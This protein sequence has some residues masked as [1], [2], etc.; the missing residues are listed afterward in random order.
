[1]SIITN[2]QFPIINYKDGKSYK[3]WGQLHGEEFK[4]SIRELAQI[5]KSLMLAKNPRLMPKLD[6]LA[7]EQFDITFQF[8]PHIAEEIQGIAEGSNSALTDIVILN[9]Y[10][11]FRDLN[12]S[13]EGCSTIHFQN[14]NEIFAG[15]TW[16]MHKSAKNFLCILNIPQTINHSPLLVLSLVGCVGLMG[17]NTNNCL[18]GVNNINTTNAKTGMIWPALVRKVLEL[19]N[20]EKMFDLLK[21]APV[22]SGHNYLISTPFGSK[23][24]EITPELNEV[25]GCLNK[26]EFGSI[27]HTN[28]CLGHQIQKVED[29]SSISSTTFNRFELLSQKTTHIKN[30]SDFLDLL[31]NHDEYPKSICSHFENGTQDPSFTCGGGASDLNLGKHIFWRGCKTYDSDYIK[32]EFII[33]DNKFKLI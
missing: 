4:H 5:R 20:L 12:F 31:S 21:T 9:N 16:D 28:H 29:K 1:M 3:N 18:I 25:V 17:I 2:C 32:H 15:Q 14:E 33:E 23:Q 6:S 22:T 11:D 19:N 8:C 26:N 30:F 7:Q 13:D 24:V 10:T 27:F